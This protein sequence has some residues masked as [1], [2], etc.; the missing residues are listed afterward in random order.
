MTLK[1]VVYALLAVMV[2]L[3]YSWIVG[4]VPEFPLAAGDFSALVVWGVGLIFGGWQIS[5]VAYT[6]RGVLAARGT[7]AM[8]ANP[9]LVPFAWKNVLCAIMATLL[10][11]AYSWF[12]G[13]FPDFPMTGETFV[14]LFLWGIGLLVGGWQVTKSHYVASNRLL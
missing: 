13:Y 14:G 3:A 7:R 9:I 6:G 4:V 2:P 11:F 12:T 8:V 1:N 10:P 5:K